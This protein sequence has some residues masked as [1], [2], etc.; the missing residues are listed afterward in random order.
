MCSKLRLVISS[1][2]R[3]YPR[4]LS[5]M[6]DS[7]SYSS[8]FGVSAATSSLRYMQ[9]LVQSSLLSQ[10]LPLQARTPQHHLLN[11]NPTHHRP[12]CCKTWTPV[13]PASSECFIKTCQ[14]SSSRS[15]LW[16]CKGSIRCARSCRQSS[17]RVWSSRR[18]IRSLRINRL[19]YMWQHW[20][21]LGSSLNLI[22]N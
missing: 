21:V 17:C 13:S 15:A 19:L 10:H 20:I 18:L 7:A 9:V 3:S 2:K 4:V 8:N 16:S 1:W 5:K 11:N 6:W 14:T 12:C 22:R